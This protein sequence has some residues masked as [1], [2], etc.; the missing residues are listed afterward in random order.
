MPLRLG[1]H[2]AKIF[3]RSE[4]LNRYLQELEYVV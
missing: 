1:M 3:D 4:E 2:S